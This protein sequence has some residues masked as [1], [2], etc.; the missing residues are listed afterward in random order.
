MATVEGSA[1]SD[2]ANTFRDMFKMGG[3]V[4]CS[5]TGKFKYIHIAVNM[6]EEIRIC[7]I[8]VFTCPCS[9]YIGYRDG[10]SDVSLTF[11]FTATSD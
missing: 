1:D 3:V 11:D 10:S 7:N 4:T 9:N 8:G 2:K 5:D 6:D